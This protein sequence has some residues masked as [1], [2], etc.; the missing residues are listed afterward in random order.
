MS[1]E[2]GTCARVD[3]PF[4]TALCMGDQCDTVGERSFPLENGESLIPN[5]V[6][7]AWQSTLSQSRL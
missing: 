7:K 3:V 4:S 6:Q 2:S 5:S 1:I